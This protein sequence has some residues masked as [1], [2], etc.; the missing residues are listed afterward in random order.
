MSVRW[1]MK[2]LGDHR[3]WTPHIQCHAN[4]FA[5]A[6][7]RSAGLLERAANCN[8]IRR[9]DLR[10]ECSKCF[11]DVSPSAEA[12]AK[13]T[14]FDKPRAPRDCRDEMDIPWLPRR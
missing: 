1:T 8:E 14:Q 5:V 13:S 7:E 3:L 9:A 4:E 11:A 10:T 12:S 6:F 2:L